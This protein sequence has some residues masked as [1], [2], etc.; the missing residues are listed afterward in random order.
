[1]S[2]EFEASIVQY[3]FLDIVSFTKDRSVDA[4]T[5]IVGALNLIIRKALKAQFF[6]LRGYLF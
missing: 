4:Q 3:V 1:M 2:E 5:D 6:Y